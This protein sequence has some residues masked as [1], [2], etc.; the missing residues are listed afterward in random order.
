MS[1]TS[2]LGM[3]NAN[4]L[5]MQYDNSYIG[6]GCWDPTVKMDVA[7]DFHTL[8]NMR[9]LGPASFS[10]TITLGSNNGA[11][12]LSTS[13]NNLGISTAAP[14]EKLDVTG[15]IQSSM[16]FLSTQNDSADA[17]SYSF[18]GNSNTGM[19]HAALDQLAFSTTG[20]ER[21]RVDAQGNIGIGLTNPSEQ[22]DV[23]GNTILRSNVTVLGKL[24]VSNVTYITSNVF[25]YSSETVQSNLTIENQS[26]HYGAANFS[27]IIKLGSNNGDVTFT[28]SNSMLGIN[29]SNTVAP[30]ADLDISNGNILA[31]NFTKLAKT[32]DNSNP[33]TLTLNWDKE[34]N[35]HNMYHIVADVHQS[36]ANGDNAGFKSQ[37][38]AIG[39]SNSTISWVTNPT[40]FGDLTAY[41]TLNLAVSAQTTR[42]M[43]LTSSTSWTAPGNYTHAMNVDVV[44]F[45]L[46]S[47]IGNIYLT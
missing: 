21:L 38:I 6:V 32:A 44:N 16:Q 34:H 19:F 1:S 11:V 47:N 15:K 40:T 17:P 9:A 5:Y 20:V 26:F 39:L 29:L 4:I 36:I 28:N 8:S 37:R 18:T 45:P 2:F 42:S 24:T 31:K 12:V 7:G 41:Q 22:L 10:N 35:L 13:N 14:V 30:R 43:T 23:Q 27:N 46:T 33:L 25:I 3:N